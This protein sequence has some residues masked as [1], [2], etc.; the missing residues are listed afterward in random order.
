MKHAWAGK[1]GRVNL[2]VLTRWV[3]PDL[4]DRA[5]AGNARADQVPNALPLQFM[6]YYVLALALFSQDSYEDVMDNLV[7]GIPELAPHVPAKSSIFAA[8]KRLGARAMEEVLRQVA[9]QVATQQTPGAF[10]RGRLVMAIDGFM[11]DVAHS[12]ENRDHFGSTGDEKGEAAY[13]E[14]R[15]VSLV[16]A[17]TRAVRGA[18]I[19]QSGFGERELTLDLVPLTGPDMIVI[20]DRGFP[21]CE[22]IREFNAAKSAVVM[23][24]ASN[25]AKNSDSVL[26]DGSY[27]AQISSTDG[28]GPVTVRVVEYQVDGRV[29]IRLLTNLLDPGQAP[30]RELAE[31]Y[32]QRWESESSNRQVKTFQQGPEA[33][34]RSGSPK[35]VLQEIWAYL[36]VNHCPSRLAGAI[37]GKRRI[38]PDGTSF[39]RLLK[40]ARRSV[41]RQSADT[42][43]KAVE[44][45]RRG[46]H[47]VLP[48]RIQPGTQPRGDLERGHQTARRSPVRTTQPGRAD[49]VHQFPPTPPP[50]ATRP[51]RGLVRQGRSPL[52]SSL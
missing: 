40:E 22:L 14:A 15:V 2:G 26:T 34:L 8:R 43:A 13:P 33:V 1:T 9:R 19:G 48:A 31:L 3:P 11:L 35:L 37:S 45:A 46:D 28:G 30:A 20:I 21:S 24:A 39:T 29:P 6:V 7:S 16:E 52:R 23:R 12:Q 50:E 17:G 49:R 27:L 47:P 32:S 10:W 5:V 51:R 4:I 41:I 18:A 36:T 44:A 38:D 25:I 42:V